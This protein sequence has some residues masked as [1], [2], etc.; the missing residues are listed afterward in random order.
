[1][2]NKEALSSKKITGFTLIEVLITLTIIAILMS[3]VAPYVLNRPDQA[4]E[5]KLK[6]DFEA[7]ES[8]LA[9]Y[10]LDNGKYPTQELGF[11]HLVNGENGS[12]YLSKIPQDPW[13]SNYI[14]KIDNNN[15][16]II[17]LGPDGLLKG[18][19]EDDI[20]HVLN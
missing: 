12:K 17:S 20:S 15:I 1:M 8:A 16:E 18:P 19:D 2:K 14:Y 11:D 4:R 10:K 6:F 3:F 5:L 9:L 13:G 7:I